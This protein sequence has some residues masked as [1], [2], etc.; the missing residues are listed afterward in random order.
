MA[1]NETFEKRGVIEPGITPPEKDEHKSAAELEDC[2]AK[3]LADSVAQ[4]ASKS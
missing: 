4:A 3:R 2:V 1:D